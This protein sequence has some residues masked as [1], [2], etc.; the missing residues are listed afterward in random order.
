[1]HIDNF[2]NFLKFEK[3][4]SKHT[5]IAYKS[6]LNQFTSYILLEYEIENILE[7]NHHIIRSWIAF[8]LDSDIT[9]RSV[10]RKITSVKSFFKFLIQEELLDENPTRKILSPKSSNKLPVFLEE[11]KMEDL[12]EKIDFHN[13]DHGERDR[14]ILDVFYM[15]G[16]RLAELINLNISDINFE[17]DSIKV[18]G[19]RN[20]ERVIPL[21]PGLL[22][23]LKKFT[24]KICKSNLLFTCEKEKKLTPKKVYNIVH[25][26]LSEVSSIKKKS[27]HVLRHTF[28][29]HMLNN[30]ADINAIKEILGHSNLRATQVYTHNTIDRLKSI[31]KQAHPRA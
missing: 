29:T 19:K 27:P 23:D 4:Y 17:N 28:A 12:F 26:Y 25:K 24:Q 20:K 9:S 13:S 21:P 15:T 5:I 14:L 16:I 7:V 1:M 3:R 10:N 22:I 18:I 8:L 11:S 30:G 31:Y 6:D 2:I